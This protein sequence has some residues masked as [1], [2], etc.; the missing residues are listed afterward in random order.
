MPEGAGGVAVECAGC[1]G[2][3]SLPEA[4]GTPAERGADEHF[5]SAGRVHQLSAAK[6][7]RLRERSYV[8]IGL[9]LLLGTAGILAMKGV[10]DIRAAGGEKLRAGAYLVIAG[11]CLVGAWW[12]GAVAVRLTRELKER[13]Q[14]D[15]AMPPD[16]GPLADGSQRYQNLEEIR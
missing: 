2:A 9:G 11:A 1:G 6:R 5:L 16:F 13:A 15:P 10:V 12:L 7:G 3:F 4:V 8:L 14:E